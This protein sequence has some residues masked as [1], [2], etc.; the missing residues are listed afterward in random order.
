MVF[1]GF[2]LC[3]IVLGIVLL[4]YIKNAQDDF[5][6]T[7][8]SLLM[9][10]Y[11][12][13]H[14]QGFL[15]KEPIYKPY[16]YGSTGISENIANINTFLTQLQGTCSSNINDL[17]NVLSDATGAGQSL[18]TNLQKLYDTYK[19]KDIQAKS[20]T[21]QNIVTIPIYIKNLGPTTTND[22]YT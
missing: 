5:N 21:N 3:I 13:I 4:V 10:Q 9:F 20:P 16:W 11:Q 19:S 1:F 22:S 14:G 7:I 12:I 6:G 2:A 8:C 17:N 15:A 18:K